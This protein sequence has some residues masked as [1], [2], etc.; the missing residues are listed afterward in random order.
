MAR[1]RRGSRST[2]RVCEDFTVVNTLSQV[3]AGEMTEQYRLLD[4]KPLSNVGNTPY[5]N[6]T[7]S[8][9]VVKRCV[10]SIPCAINAGSSTSGCVLVGAVIYKA[11]WDPATSD[12]SLQ[13]PFATADM[14]MDNVLWLRYALYESFLTANPYAW[15]TTPPPFNVNIG[16]IRLQEGEALYLNIGVNVQ[17]AGVQGSICF[18]PMIRTQFGKVA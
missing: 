18:A 15:P 16:G 3:G 1:R 17:T 8:E 14:N 5:E 10:G 2:W 9:V 13:S 11:T 12:W 4:M 7:I 6:P